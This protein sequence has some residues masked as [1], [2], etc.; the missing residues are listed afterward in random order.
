MPTVLKQ[1][2]LV[3]FGI[4]LF[5]FFGYDQVHVQEFEIDEKKEEQLLYLNAAN[6]SN[7]KS[8]IEPCKSWLE[9]DEVIA[10]MDTI[11]AVIHM[12]FYCSCSD[13]LIGAHVKL[14]NKDRTYERITDKSGCDFRHIQSGKYRMEVVHED[15][16]KFESVE[17]LVISGAIT[18]WKV[19]LCSQ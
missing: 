18:R 11:T 3:L 16:Q 19:F 6:T 4:L 17:V 10:L 5:P 9:E 1:I 15:V 13:F 2:P 7:T 8:I 12:D 14:S